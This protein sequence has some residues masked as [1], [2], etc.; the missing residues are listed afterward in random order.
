MIRFCNQCGASTIL[1]VP[2][3]DNRPRHQ[4]TAC[5]YIQYENPRMV[6]GCIATWEEKILLCRRAIEPRLGFWTL[7]AGF[8]ENGEA[9]AQAA[10]RETQEEAGATVI[11]PHPFLMV[12]LPHI[13]QIH[14][15]YRGH[16][17]TPHYAAGEESL[18]VGLFE[19]AAIP[20]PNLA[21]G[22]I[23]LGLELFLAE[24]RHGS[25]GFQERT[26]APSPHY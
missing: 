25:F 7:P 15:F 23:R 1:T 12:N 13:D 20:W 11:D 24:R 22:S 9:T 16:L 26:L 21:F 17:A 14:F 6:V 19:E 18:E 2:A 8:M 5:S 4:C 3:G 10:L